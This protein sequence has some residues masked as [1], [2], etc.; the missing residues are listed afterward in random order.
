MAREIRSSEATGRTAV[1]YL[2]NAAD[3]VFIR[4]VQNFYWKDD[5]FQVFDGYKWYYFP[6][7]SIIYATA[8]H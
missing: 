5:S 2:I 4:D 6:A 8:D 1:V 7:R 3:P